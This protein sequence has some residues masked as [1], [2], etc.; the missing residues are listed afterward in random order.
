MGRHRTAD[1]INSVLRLVETGMSHREIA[2]VTGIP[3]PT[4]RNWLYRGIP[5][6][7]TGPSLT[8]PHACP[9][10][11][12]VHDL[13]AAPPRVYAYLLGVYLGDGHIC[14]HA[15]RSHSLRVSLDSAYPGIVAEVAGAVAAIRGRWPWVK[16]RPGMNMFLVVSYWKQWPCWFPQHG[17]GRKHTRAIAL[18]PWQRQIVE[19]EPERFLRGLIQTDGW[20]GL[21]R[22][23]A[24]GRDY[25]YPRYQFSNR[26][27]DI[28]G[29]FTDACDQLGI[30]WRPWG[31]HHISVARREAVAGLDEFVGPKT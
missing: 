13:A 24:K 19:Q 18:E 16:R 30:A 14:Q 15:G 3:A 11:G 22:V 9:A 4:F 1:E 12:G 2:N 28:K 21:N 26:S 23:R 20:R 27:V 8:R 10:C 31:P 29:L 17:P 5:S 25:A 7:F 6:R